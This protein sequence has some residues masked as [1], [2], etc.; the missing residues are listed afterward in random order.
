VIIFSDFKQDTVGSYEITLDWNTESYTKVLNETTGEEETYYAS[1][2]NQPY[3]IDV[4]VNDIELDVL[5][6]ESLVEYGAIVV[7]KTDYPAIITAEE[8]KNI[9]DSMSF[10]I[11]EGSDEVNYSG[12]EIDFISFENNQELRF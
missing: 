4:Q 8:Q 9:L 6:T 2:F 5:F 3:I 7:L 11:T 10:E 1:S 12:L